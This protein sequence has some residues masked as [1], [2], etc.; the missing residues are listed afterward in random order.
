MS[1]VEIALTLN[2]IKGILFLEIVDKQ[3]GF[4]YCLPIGLFSTVCLSV[5]NPDLISVSLA[6]CFIRLVLCSYGQDF[7]GNSI[8]GQISSV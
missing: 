4:V 1:I 7:Q 3:R 5:F 6:V 8:S 2:K